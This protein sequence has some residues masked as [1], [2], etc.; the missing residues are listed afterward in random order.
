MRGGWVALSSSQML[1]PVAK[2]AG[3]FDKYGLNFDL[4]YIAGSTTALAALLGG[5][6]QTLN[7][8]GT[9]VV[10]AAAGGADLAIVGIFLNEIIFNVIGPS[11]MKTLDEVKGKT[12]AVT[13]VGNTDYL[14]WQLIKSQRGWKDTD[15][16]FVPAGDPA[17]Q[18]AMLQSGQAQVTAMSPPNNV[19]AERAGFH[20][21]YTMHEQEEKNVLAVSRKYATDHRPEVLA[22]LKAGVSAAARLKK[23]AAFAKDVMRKYLK[24]SDQAFIDAG[25]DAYAQLWLQAPYPDAQAFTKVIDEA[26]IQNPKARDVNPAQLLDPSFVKELDDSGF[27]KQV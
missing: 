6:V 23:D 9:T 15:L 3:Y 17:G 22:L 14:V 1:L 12:I 8:G 27:L 10:N 5:D 2:E 20:V 25:Y 16:K 13:K 18:V 26:A 7:L 19:P 21:I 24:E 4:Q 11:G